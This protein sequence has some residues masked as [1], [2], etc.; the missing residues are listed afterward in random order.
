MIE[1]DPDLRDLLTEFLAE[2]G[3]AVVGAV[4]LDGAGGPAIGPEPYDVAFTD[5]V[6]LR[7][8]DEAQA[9]RW[10]ERVRTI[11]ARVVVVTGQAGAMSSGA[12]ALGADLLLGKPFD[13]DAILAAV[14]PLTV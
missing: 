3:S 12:A 4:G 14:G 6:A 8:Y 9:R 11:A 10:I 13:L 5:L 1:D 7:A 2:D